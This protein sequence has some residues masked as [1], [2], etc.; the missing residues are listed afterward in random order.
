MKYVQTYSLDTLEQD[1]FWS[2][3]MT[4]G[5]IGPST[6]VQMR[7]YFHFNKLKAD[8]Q[9]TT[10]AIT[11]TAAEF[12]VS[13]SFVYKAINKFKR[14]EDCYRDTYQGRQAQAAEASA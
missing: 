12:R 9:N 14:Y 4:A 11:D 13:E 3:L 5:I 1:G 2:F 6:I 10:E 8:K 7:A